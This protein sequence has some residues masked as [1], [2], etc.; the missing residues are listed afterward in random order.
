[1][2]NGDAD[3]RHSRLLFGMA[4]GVEQSFLMGRLLLWI[5]AA[6]TLFSA[7]DYTRKSLPSL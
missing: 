6:L 2:E 4:Y 1:M 7:Y 3:G 5:A